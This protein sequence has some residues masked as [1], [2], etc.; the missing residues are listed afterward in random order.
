[1]FTNALFIYFDVKDPFK[2]DDAQRNY[3]LQDLG[4]LIVKNQLPL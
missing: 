2:K 1:V 3:F 4:F